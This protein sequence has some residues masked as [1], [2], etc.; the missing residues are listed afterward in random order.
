[1]E[2]IVYIVGDVH[3]TGGADPFVE[4]LQALARRRP[5]RLVILGDLFDYWLETEAAVARHAPVIA[6][7]R[8]LHEAGWR[9]DLIR[10]NREMVAGRRLA[11]ALRT[12]LR[13]PELCFQLG[14]RRVRVVHGDRLCHDPGY[15]LLVAFLTAFPMQVTR[16]CVPGVIQEAV[17][18]WMRR[19]SR[20][21]ATAAGAC[22]A[23]LHP[24]RI[25]RSGR[26]VDTVVAGHIH[27][28]WRRR[29]CGVDVMLVGDWQGGDGRWI[30]GFPDGRLTARC[31]SIAAFAAD[32]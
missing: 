5:A 27:E 17:A 8:T 31:A 21:N 23:R 10:G 11:A 6:A 25:R 26:A 12:P 29:L 3:L 1:M 2:P 16:W 18:R 19:R 15:H 13:W 28:A 22:P 7:L 24:G 30:E 14:P 9:L 4:W 32:R 20:G